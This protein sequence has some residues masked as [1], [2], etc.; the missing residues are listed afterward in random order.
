[1]SSISSARTRVL[2]ICVTATV[3]STA[4]P[5]WAQQAQTVNAERIT[6]AGSLDFRNVYMF[7]GIRQDDTGVITWPAVEV[8]LRLHSAD[9]G[10]TNV[11][12][13]VGTFNSFFYLF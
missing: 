7:R 4:I 9:H 2:I 6:V 12:V 1:M 11:R 13:H 8:A 10:L 5:L 3:I